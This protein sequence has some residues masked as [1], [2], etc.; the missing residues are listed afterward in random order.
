MSDI[1]G[2]SEDR[3]NVVISASVQSIDGVS[4][5]PCV[6]RDASKNGCQIVT[7]QVNDLPD[8]ICIK[9][10]GLKSP[11]KGEIIWRT[12]NRAGVKFAC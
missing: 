1:N 10:P 11:M 6:I 2:R 4:I 5:T 12:K 9:I 3:K 7:S 8:T